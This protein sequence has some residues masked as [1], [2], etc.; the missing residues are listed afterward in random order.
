MWDRASRT[1]RDCEFGSEHTTEKVNMSFSPNK[2]LDVNKCNNLPIWNWATVKELFVSLG[3]Q[4]DRFNVT[5]QVTVHNKSTKCDIIHK[6]PFCW[7][8]SSDLHIKQNLWDNLLTP[9]A[10]HRPGH[11]LRAQSP[12]WPRNPPKYQPPNPTAMIK[13]GWYSQQKPK[14]LNSTQLGLHMGKMLSE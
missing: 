9:F 5:K 6:A 8:F 13:W 11:L 2:I 1:G 10:L 14:C 12:N 7:H 4:Q 3:E